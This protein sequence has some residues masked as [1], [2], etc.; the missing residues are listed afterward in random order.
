VHPKYFSMTAGVPFALDGAGNAILY[1]VTP[2]L[3]RGLLTGATI[4]SS[5]NA[6]VAASEETAT[7]LHAAG[8][9]VVSCVRFPPPSS[10]DV[11]FLVFP[12]L[13]D[14]VSL[15]KA[16]TLGL[17][18]CSIRAVRCSSNTGGFRGFSFDGAA[19]TG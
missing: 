9:P 12:V 2:Q 18:C 19:A 4:C 15:M 1:H 5:P 17:Q 10:P 7:A 16:H 8:L 13:L 6:A 11:H 3:I 14:G